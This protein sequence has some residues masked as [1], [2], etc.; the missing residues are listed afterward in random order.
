MIILATVCTS[1]VS[2]CQT[3][4]IQ[5]PLDGVVDGVNVLSAYSAIFQLRAPSKNYVHLRGD[6]NEFAIN[7]ASLMHQSLDGTRHS[8]LIC[9]VPSA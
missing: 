7:N 1:A 9:P 6:F 4:L 3:P 2:M 5:D 8:L